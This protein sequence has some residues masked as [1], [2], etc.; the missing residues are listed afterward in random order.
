MRRPKACPTIFCGNSDMANAPSPP[1]NPFPI[2]P[3]SSLRD[4][5]DTI[6]EKTVPTD[7]VEAVASTVAA[8]AS[9]AD[10][11]ADRRS[12]MVPVRGDYGTGKTHLLL[13]AK[14]LL[15]KLWPDGRVLALSAPG[16]EAD[17]AR[18]YV[19]VLGPAIT[20]L[21]LDRVFL[22]LLAGA[23]G[24]VAIQVPLTAGEAAYIREDP[25][26]VY[27]VLSK[28]LLSRTDVE[29]VV[30][31][32]V[33]ALTP[34]GSPGLRGA[35]TALIWRERK[36]TPTRWLVG[37]PLQPAEREGLGVERDLDV[38][39]EAASVLV[40]IARACARCGTAFVLIIDE[41]EH[42]MAEDRRTETRRNATWFKRVLEGLSPAGALV[43]VAGHW[44]AWEQLPDFQDRFGRQPPVD[45]V[46]LTGR[47]VRLLLD[48]AA[49]DWSKRLDDAALDAVAEAGGRNIRRVLA[50]LHQ[51]YA[52]T[53]HRSGPVGAAAVRDTE[54]LRVTQERGPA[55]EEL[56]QEAV[57]AAGGEI[58]SGELLLGRLRFD[59]VAQRGAEIRLV[60]EVKH[61]TTEIGLTQMLDDFAIAVAAVRR[62]H[63][64][65]KGLLVISGA[66]EAATLSLLDPLPG[67][68]AL[69]A[70]GGEIR[71]AVAEALA[72]EVSPANDQP[73]SSL[74]SE[75][76]F[77]AQQRI[78]E[79]HAYQAHEAG[80][81][82]LRLKN[83]AYGS[84]ERDLAA[85]ETARQALKPESP[86]SLLGPNRKILDELLRGIQMQGPTIVSIMLNGV[87]PLF[88]I[89]AASGAALLA[90]F[91]SL[92]H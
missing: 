72:G 32:A 7:A 33:E 14:A 50:V 20:K 4:I 39:A 69:R 90:F 36:D 21:A 2:Y 31:A 79:A 18:W 85:A 57:R 25:L 41:F 10:A 47:E 67:V 84:S 43:L 17:F 35:L 16:T 12:T 3:V 48:K 27:P 42:L 45:L 52:T 5:A 65:A 23:A 22:E 37:E 60:A 11:R 53:A 54:N 28:G 46:A 15:E 9:R 64:H 74:K 1:P 86:D 58:M 40:A 34:Q 13:Y 19:Q 89:A 6:L 77:A 66:G 49:P 8:Y 78:R 81:T 92:D 61:A 26:N 63:P 56:L 83:L 87:G 44:Q 82:S 51:L 76:E 91:P 29:R 68:K 80:L 30:N 73:P 24:E 70:D 75:A 62:R 71:K 59:L 88:I 38:D 55:P